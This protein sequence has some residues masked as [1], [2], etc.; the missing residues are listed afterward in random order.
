MLKCCCIGFAMILALTMLFG[1]VA[2]AVAYRWTAQHVVRWTVVKEDRPLTSVFDKGQPATTTAFPIVEISPEEIRSIRDRTR[3]FKY[4]ILA[5]SAA[6][7][8]ADGKQAAIAASVDELILT[9]R[10]CNGFLMDW[11][12]LFRGNVHIDIQPGVLTVQMSIPVTYLPGGHGRIFDAT[13]VIRNDDLSRPQRVLAILHSD[14]LNLGFPIFEVDMDI[15]QHESIGYKWTA[16]F[17]RVGFMGSYLDFTQ[18]PKPEGSDIVA[19]F[20]EDDQIMNAIGSITM[21]QDQLVYRARKYNNVCAEEELPVVDSATTTSLDFNKR[22]YT[23][24]RSKV[25]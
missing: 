9:A 3:A 24:S 21:E 19:L 10:E 6:A 1:A 5:A 12:S 8:V 14:A 2:A 23:I 16:T 18:E 22:V 4:S 13:L 11:A 15:F 20:N 17:D 7:A 25:E